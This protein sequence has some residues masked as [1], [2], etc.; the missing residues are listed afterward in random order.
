MR[1]TNVLFIAALLATVIADPAVRADEAE[2]QRQKN[3]EVHGYTF[4]GQRGLTLP[5]S[6]RLELTGDGTIEFWL[7][8]A[9]AASFRGEAVVV[10]LSDGTNARYVV[11]LKKDDAGLSIGLWDGV[12]D[13]AQRQPAITAPLG[14][15]GDD[16]FFYHI[17]LVTT[18]DGTT[19]YKDGGRVQLLGG[20]TYG[21]ARGLPLHVG[22]ADGTNGMYQGVI[23]GLRIWNAALTQNTIKAFSDVGDGPTMTALAKHPNLN[24]LVLYSDF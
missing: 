5:A 6:S 13:F 10:A 24:S 3:C 2:N 19:V 15:K 14:V 12:G 22:S 23:S 17:A 18:R 7:D 20:A 9:W 1:S 11:Y 16:Q 21:A 8:P 4:F